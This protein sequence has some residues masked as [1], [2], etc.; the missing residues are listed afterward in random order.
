M[1]LYRVHVADKFTGGGVQN[2][3]LTGDALDVEGVRMVRM[4]HGDIRGADGWHETL[5]A[6]QA[7]AAE[8]IETIGRKAIQ[9]AACLREAAR[10]AS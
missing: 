1:K 6:A 9:Q 8:R 2:W 4:A 3:L 5:A 10:G 7:A